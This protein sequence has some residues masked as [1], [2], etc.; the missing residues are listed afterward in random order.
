MSLRDATGGLRCEH[1][2]GLQASEFSRHNG[3]SRYTCP[4]PARRDIRGNNMENL[5]ERLDIFNAQDS[6]LHC[7]KLIDPDEDCFCN[8]GCNS[9]Y[10]KAHPK[11]EYIMAG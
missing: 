2:A 10:D 3:G 6:C 7:G 4:T 5:A 11:I 8:L 1:A 9:A